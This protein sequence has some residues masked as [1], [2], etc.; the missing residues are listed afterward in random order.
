M[1]QQEEENKITNSKN[2]CI[3]MFTAALFTIGKKQKRKKKNQKEISTCRS[4]CER[5]KESSHW[6]ASDSWG[7][8]ETEG[9]PQSL[10]E[11]HSSG[12]E[13]YKAE[14][15]TQT[16]GTTTQHTIA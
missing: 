8:A 16:I 13:E 6:E 2:I 1:I 14:R 3:N 12:S 11:K 4:S 10:G 15:A 7:S 5:G 9:D